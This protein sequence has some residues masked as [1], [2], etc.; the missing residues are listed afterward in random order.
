[1]SAVG[2]LCLA[3]GAVASPR[4]EPAIRPI[5]SQVRDEKGP[6][7]PTLRASASAYA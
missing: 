4:I 2:R 3:I 5:G 1:M 7:H 6:D